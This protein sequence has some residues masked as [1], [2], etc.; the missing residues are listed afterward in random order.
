MFL[1]KKPTVPH[2]P[3]E[4]LWNYSGNWSDSK[5]PPLALALKMPMRK[6]KMHSY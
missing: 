3:Y 6:I 4:V 1:E 5:S 2:T